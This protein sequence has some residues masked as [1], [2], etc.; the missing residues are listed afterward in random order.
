MNE[1]TQWLAEPDKHNKPF[2]DGALAG[3]LRLQCCSAAVHAM[4]G[5]TL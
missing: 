1:V 2:F 3:E 4:A 5:C